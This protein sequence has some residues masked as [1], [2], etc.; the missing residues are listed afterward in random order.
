MEKAKAKVRDIKFYS[1]KNGG[2]ITVHSVKAKKYAD[3][4]EQDESI[5][6]YRTNVILENWQEN[7]STVGIR[8]L[9]MKLDWTSDFMLVQQDDNIAIREILTHEALEKKAEM[10]KLE[11]S[12]RYWKIAHV[13]NWGMVLAPKEGRAW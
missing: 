2:M 12:R 8:T 3:M 5:K 11:I 13:E 9:Y 7:I 1:K 4:L 6:L 10:E